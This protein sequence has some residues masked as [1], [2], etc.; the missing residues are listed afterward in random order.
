M[1]ILPL[2]ARCHGDVGFQEGGTHLNSQQELSSA[3]RHWR[4]KDVILKLDQ[5]SARRRFDSSE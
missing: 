1:T 3:E 5:V 4:G 2:E